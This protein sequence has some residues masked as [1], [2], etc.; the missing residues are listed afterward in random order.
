[1]VRARTSSSVWL[2][3]LACRAPPAG[4]SGEG[5]RAEWSR[6]AGLTVH[7]GSFRQRLILSGELAAERG[8]AMNVPRTN[9]FQ[10][11]IRWMAPDGVPVKAGDPVVAFDNSQF[12]T[13]LEEKRLSASQAGS[14][15]ATAQAGVKTNASERRFDVEKA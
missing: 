6:E 4:C 13:D 11:T 7:R 12:S 10:L 14:D 15:L 3:L 8:E 1:M 9:A 2:L 5:A